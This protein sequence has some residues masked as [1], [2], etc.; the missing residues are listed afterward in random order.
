[1]SDKL[2]G[3]HFSSGLR[4]TD[5]VLSGHMRGDIARMMGRQ[6]DVYAEAGKYSLAENVGLTLNEYKAL[7]FILE[8]NPLSPGQLAQLLNLSASGASAL[9][10]RLEQAGYIH[11][12]RHPADKRM[13]AL[14]PDLKQC[15][16]IMISMEESVARAIERTASHNPAQLI[17]IYDFL[18]NS[19]AS[20][21]ASALER[22]KHKTD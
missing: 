8:L 16:Q 2:P 10:G 6:L 13:V 4:N 20:L 22:L 11:R 15:R 1:M 7:E 21:R 18:F 12:S 19:I 17:A 9:I 5:D 3:T 14:Y